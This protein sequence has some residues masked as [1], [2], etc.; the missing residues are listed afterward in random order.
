MASIWRCKNCGKEIRD[1]VPDKCPHCGVA[2]TGDYKPDF[3][4]VATDRSEGGEG[5]VQFFFY[6]FMITI[7]FFVAGMLHMNPIWGAIIF[8]LVVRLI[9]RS[10]VKSSKNEKL[11][12]A[13]AIVL[14]VLIIVITV[15]FAI[16]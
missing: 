6:I 11:F 4:S 13:G 5:C 10:V 3:D 9:W 2:L 1:H 14:I 8:P 7:G 16:I 12:D 15:I